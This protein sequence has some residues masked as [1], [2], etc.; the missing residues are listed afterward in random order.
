MLCVFSGLLLLASERHVY[1]LHGRMYRRRSSSKVTITCITITWIGSVII[2]L[3]PI[4]GFGTYDYDKRTS[5][6]MLNHQHYRNN[7]TLVYLL[8]T[9]FILGAIV[10]LYVRMFIYMREHRRMFPG[11]G[12][13]PMQSNDWSFNYAPPNMNIH[14]IPRAV[15]YPI[16]FV[17]PHQQVL[18]NR[19]HG[20]VNSPAE[21]I[22][23]KKLIYIFLV[24]TILYMASFLPYFTVCLWL[25]LSDSVSRGF[26]TVS[27]WNR[28]THLLT[29][30]SVLL[31]WIRSKKIG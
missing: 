16:G 30:P 20:T 29:V 22:K 1:T 7:D 24:I 12:L 19:Q 5:T 23:S 27:V 3:P 31:P 14:N 13:R 8:I 2:S 11:D 26:V 4:F 21:R 9:I 25:T 28:Y 6:C 17:I 10:L 18:Q 15:T